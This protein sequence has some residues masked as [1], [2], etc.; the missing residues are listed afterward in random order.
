MTGNIGQIAD[1]GFQTDGSSFSGYIT[2]TASVAAMVNL[3]NEVSV[4]T[5][6]PGLSGVEHLGASGCVF[7]FLTFFDL[8]DFL[9]VFRLVII[10]CPCFSDLNK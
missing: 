10:F 1:K 8:V 7:A 5:V 4:F 6:K 2:V 3:V 9:L